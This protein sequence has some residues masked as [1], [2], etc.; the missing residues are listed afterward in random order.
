MPPTLVT[1]GVYVEEVASGVRAIAGVATS[2]AAFVGRAARGP[3]GAEDGGPLTVQSFAE[4]ERRFGGL[5][6]GF[7]MAYAVRD[8]FA[9]G[10]TRA[11][12]VRVFK[13][14]DGEAGKARIAIGHLRLV[15][16]SAG[17]WGNH[18]RVRIDADV[19]A[20]VAASLGLATSDVFNLTVR[21]TECGVQETFAALSIKDS[22]RRID[23]VL[24][25]ESSL[26]RVD[27]TLVRLG[28]TPPA[29]HAAVAPG[30]SLWNDDAYSTGV[31]PEDAAGD[32]AA[33][34]DAAYQGDASDANGLHALRKVD[35]FNLLCLP[36][37]TRDGD[38]APAVYRA[39][40]ALCV[41]RR[42]LLLVDAPQG[43]IDVETIARDHEQLLVDLG[44]EGVAARNAA[45]YFPR[46]RQA[47]ALRAGQVDTFVPCGAVAGVIARTDVERGVWKAPA[48]TEAALRGVQGLAVALDDHDNGQLNPIAVNCLREF[49]LLG[50]L[51]WGARTLRGGDAYG[52]DYKYVPVRR[53]AMHVEESLLRGTQWAVF[54]PNSEALWARLR[55]EVGSFMQGLFRAG[56]L[57]GASPRDAWFVKCDASTTTQ[58]DIELGIVEIV[59]GF[60]PLKPAEFVVLQLRQMTRPDGG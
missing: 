42:A 43:W 18:L 49:P 44:I 1:P 41:E 8:F 33:L 2:I 26:L 15:A 53:L 45:L 3:V 55:Q 52:D 51:V 29:A 12:V 11:V 37:D 16:A 19:S 21:D 17:A 32:G 14:V 5:H 10:G 25:A 58:A 9:N 60:A 24:A 22:A 38:T 7:P 6:P 47:D 27:D 23:R 59:V 35:L 39:A 48:G 57:Q 13:P 54:E 46:L 40:L 56:A 20:A 31:A 30:S 4:F 34:D 50:P 36:P 28:T